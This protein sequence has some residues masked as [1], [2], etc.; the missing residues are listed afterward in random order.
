MSFSSVFMY[1]VEIE[2]DGDVSVRIRNS[3][4][5]VF[6][7]DHLLLSPTEVISLRQKLDEAILLISRFVV[8]GE[9]SDDDD[10]PESSSEVVSRAVKAADLRELPDGEVVMP[11]DVVRFTT[12]YACELVRF[13]E[14]EDTAIVRCSNNQQKV[15][16]HLLAGKVCVGDMVRV[17]EEGVQ[18]AEVMEVQNG[19]LFVSLCGGEKRWVYPGVVSVLILGGEDEGQG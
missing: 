1:R 9:A 5:T 2:E 11:G 17:Y 19:R 18:E 7:G 14:E 10:G 15:A 8:G 12:G 13:A 6:G 4:D 16:L 3:D